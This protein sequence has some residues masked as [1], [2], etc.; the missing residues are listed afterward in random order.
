MVVYIF[1]MCFFFMSVAPV[2]FP[3]LALTFE[4]HLMYTETKTKDNVFVVVVVAVQVQVVRSFKNVFG[5]I[6]SN[7]TVKKKYFMLF[8]LGIACSF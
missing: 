3:L 7:N 2:A 6:N 4:E 1:L 8:S 5:Q